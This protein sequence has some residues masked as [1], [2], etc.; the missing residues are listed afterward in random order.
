MFHVTGCSVEMYHRV[1]ALFY[2]S[3]Q[4]YR[5]LSLAQELQR[6]WNGIT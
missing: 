4:E 1:P 5:C 6:M 3:V 2:A